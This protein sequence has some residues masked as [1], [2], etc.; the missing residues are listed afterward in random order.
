MKTLTDSIQFKNSGNANEYI[1]K[2]CN[3]CKFEYYDRNKVIIS[4]GTDSR[5]KELNVY[6]ILQGTVSV[7]IDHYSN[8]PKNWNR[9]Q[10]KM[11]RSNFF[12]QITTTYKSSKSPITIGD[13]DGTENMSISFE[14]IS[15][16]SLELSKL[17]KQSEQEV[18]KSDKQLLNNIV[19]V[20]CLDT[21]EDKLK[22]KSQR[23]PKSNIFKAN[24]SK[25]NSVINLQG[26]LND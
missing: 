11:K 19:T 17:D 22:R 7:V 1:S 2:I 6:F 4:Q 21:S 23:S 20:D 3:I 14:A 8:K 26:K 25:E 13:D 24:T 12:N 10:H 15:E 9:D 5:L 16:E 18:S